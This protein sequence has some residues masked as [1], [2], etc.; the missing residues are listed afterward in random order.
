MVHC[1]DIAEG[2]MEQ[3]SRGND[4]V[5]RCARNG[6]LLENNARRKSLTASRSG[7]SKGC[8]RRATDIP[9][10]HAIYCK[11]LTL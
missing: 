10:L 4:G 3:A 1:T 9:P 8:R 6:A 5:R 2:T 7:G 11:R